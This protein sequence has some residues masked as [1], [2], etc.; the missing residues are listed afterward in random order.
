MDSGNS[1]V[2]ESLLKAPA[3]GRILS[4]DMGNYVIKCYSGDS[5]ACRCACPLNLDIVA[6]NTKLKKGNFDSAYMLYRDQVI[7]PAIVCRLCDQPC[8]RACVRKEIDDSL[9]MRLLEKAAVDYT[10]STTPVKYN[11]PPKNK[12]IA[13]VGAGLCGLSCTARL[14]TRGYNATIFEKSDRVGGRLWDLLPP[15]SFLEEIANQMQ[16]LN[17][18]MK[19]NTWIKNIDGLISA[20]DAVLLA[21]G[22][23][24]D[25]FNLLQGI[26]LDS[27]GSTQMGVFLA[28]G[29]IGANPVQAIE[30]GI[31][32]AQSIESYLQINRMHEIIGPNINKPSR[33][34]MNTSTIKP[35]KRIVAESY[36]KDAV[37]KEAGRCIQCDCRDCINSCDMMKWYKKMPKRIVN[38]VRMSFNPVEGLQPRVA[39][40]MLNSCNNCGLCGS[41]CTEDINLGDFLLDARRIMH[42]EGSLPPA[43]HDFWIRDMLFTESEKAYLSRN[44]PDCPKSEYVF[45]PGCQLGASDPAYV[46]K[47]YGYL[48]KI[49]PQTGIML[50]CCGVPAEWA[51][52]VPL[53][54]ETLEKIRCQWDGMGKPTVI[55]AC[56][57]C[58]K[59]FAKYLPEADRVSL[60]DVIEENGL[61]PSHTVSNSVVSIFD[62]CSSRYDEAM[63]QSVRKLVMKAGLVIEELPYREKTAQCCGYGG[64]IYSANP[65]LAKD[66]A[67]KRV[68]LGQY[69]YITYCT[70]CR[71]VFADLQKPCR[72]VLDVLFDINDDSR[73]PPSLTERRHNRVVLK[74]D[75]LKNIWREDGYS[76][77]LPTPSISISHELM[78]KLN[79]H[80]ITEDD[81]RDTI[82]FC[83]TSG[84]KI[85]DTETGYYIGHQKQKF[86]TYWVI[87]QVEGD[88][89]KLINAYC[90]RLSIEG[91]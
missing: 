40:R 37:I 53:F 67:A 73:K 42:R 84:N 12:K 77:V 66:I 3:S 20:F 22:K 19:F 91:E 70:N 56:P 25:S 89:Y 28:G 90:H 51:G 41:V 5:P 54:T 62:P 32:A 59:M 2:L 55:V 10:R 50:G 69:P 87:Y 38:D 86:I 85:F 30:H 83:E 17:Y 57:T 45:F 44:A 34:K 7:F 74:A 27:L 58:S 16:F 31:R 1:K 18:E 82:N 47:S 48:L 75:L 49:L 15:E 29:L 14:V 88:S 60:Y 46:K 80:L 61:Q 23:N 65:D 71:D 35:E 11:V 33:F 13:I 63:Q 43:F 8:E 64:H 76:V 79:K 81:I 21:T 72:H 6:F 26:N 24:G 78:Q 4:K 36:S 68:A 9:S 39:T 52:N